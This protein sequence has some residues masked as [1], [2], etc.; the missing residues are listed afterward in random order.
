MPGRWPDFFVIGAMKAGTTTLHDYLVDHNQIYMAAPKEPGYF[1]QPNVYARGDQWYL[2]IF[3]D[4]AENQLLGD[5]S[6]CYS[7]WPTYPNVPERI[8]QRNPSSKF[9][10]VVRDPVKR[11]Y[12]H[13]RHR[14]EEVAVHGGEFKSF[15]K[16]IED[17]EEMLM[18]GCYSRQIEHF[19]EYFPLKNFYFVDFRRLVQEAPEVL[20]EI[21]QFLG[22]EAAEYV[23]DSKKVSNQAGEVLASHKSR[24]L[25]RAV[26][27]LPVLKW[28]FDLMGPNFRAILSDQASDIFS[29]SPWG[30]KVAQEYIGKIEPATEEE[31]NFLREYYK[32][33]NIEFTQLTGIS[34]SS[35]ESPAAEPAA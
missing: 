15:S 16:A 23:P 20:N 22:V 14:M 9:I 35:W 13:Y 34:S 25:A 18:A 32:Q 33:P 7:R 21:Y 5:G 10:Y 11:A 2:S 30:K 4:A 8:Y 28:L 17:D 31:L 3:Q 6:T 26:R 1:S 12:S 29:R 24:H 27:N 19:L